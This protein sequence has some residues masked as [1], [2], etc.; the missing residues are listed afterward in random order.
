MPVC[1]GPRDPLSRLVLL[2]VDH[3]FLNSCFICIVTAAFELIVVLLAVGGLYEDVCFPSGAE[4]R[5]YCMV[6]EFDPLMDGHEL[7][8]GL[9]AVHGPIHVPNAIEEHIYVQLG[10]GDVGSAL[11]FGVHAHRSS[12]ELAARQ[13]ALNNLFIITISLI[14][15]RAAILVLRRLL[16]MLLEEEPLRVVYSHGCI[17]YVRLILSRP[18][19]RLIFKLVEI[20]LWI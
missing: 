9:V 10:H 14:E 17:H 11:V 15:G 18:L 3:P 19:I 16:L 5:L 4:G 20:A 8:D 2:E 12:P 1:H 13:I 6:V 7:D